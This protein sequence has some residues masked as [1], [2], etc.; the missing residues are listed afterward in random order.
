[1]NVMNVM[2][3]EWES[4]FLSFAP[5]VRTQEVEIVECRN[6]ALHKSRD[7]KVRCYRVR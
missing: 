7:A 3:G 2:D 1:M 5:N 6:E 4:N